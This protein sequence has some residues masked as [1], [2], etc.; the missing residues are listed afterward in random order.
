MS[1]R[2][3]C[4][5]A[6]LLAPDAWSDSA[7]PAIQS[8]MVSMSASGSFWPNISGGI[9]RLISEYRP[10]ARLIALTTNEVTYRRLALYWG[11]T[12]LEIQPAASRT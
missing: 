1:N 10:E 3:L 7:P 5:L 2:A 6:S 8:R 12:S 11:V 4:S 9:A